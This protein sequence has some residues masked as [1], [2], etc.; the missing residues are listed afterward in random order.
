MIADQPEEW[1]CLGPRYEFLEYKAKGSF[2]TVY[3]ARDTDTGELVA[4]KY[5]KDIFR[6]NY[7]AVRVY[8][9]L[10]VHS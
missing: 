10:E 3:K 6:H 7:A 4:V 8:R 5:M 2:G 9:E 1:S